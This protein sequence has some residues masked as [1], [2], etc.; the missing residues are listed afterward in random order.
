[1]LTANIPMIPDPRFVLCLRLAA[2]RILLE[3]EGRPT[4]IIVDI[5]LLLAEAITI[6]ED[7][8]C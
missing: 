7:Y 1:M 4:S 3:T 8:K 2:L 6:F 5:D